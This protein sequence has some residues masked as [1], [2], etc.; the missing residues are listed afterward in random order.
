VHLLL[1]SETR[2]EKPLR[3]SLIKYAQIGL[4]GTTRRIQT[5]DCE[6]RWHSPE[7]ILALSW[8]LTLPLTSFVLNNKEFGV[9]SE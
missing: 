9:T 2:N 6:K 8:V 7:I 5:K 3:P 4:C 1:W